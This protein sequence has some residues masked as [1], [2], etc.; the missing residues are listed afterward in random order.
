VTRRM[1]S[2]HHCTQGSNAV[3][4][5]PPPCNVIENLITCPGTGPTHVVAPALTCVQAIPGQAASTFPN[6]P[7]LSKG[8]LNISDEFLPTKECLGLE[9][10]PRLATLSNKS[11]R[12]RIGDFA[13]QSHDHDH[14]SITTQRS[15][16]EDF[17]DTIVMSTSLTV[18]AE[19]EQSSTRF[20]NSSSLGELAPASAKCLSILNSAPAFLWYFPTWAPYNSRFCRRAFGTRF[21]IRILFSAAAL[22]AL[23]FICFRISQSRVVIMP[24]FVSHLYISISSAALPDLFFKI[25]PK[26]GQSQPDAFVGEDS[27][28][29]EMV[30]VE[31][32]SV[33]KFDK[34]FGHSAVILDF[35]GVRGGDSR[36]GAGCPSV[37]HKTHLSGSRIFVAGHVCQS[38]PVRMSGSNYVKCNSNSNCPTGVRNASG[39]V[40]SL[41][42]G[43]RSA[44]SLEP[45][46]PEFAATSAVSAMCIFPSPKEALLLRCFEGETVNLE[47][48]WMYFPPAH[49]D[50]TSRVH[51]II[52]FA[53]M[54][55]LFWILRHF[56]A[57][58]SSRVSKF[59]NV[60]AT[61]FQFVLV[62]ESFEMQPFDVCRVHD[63]PSTVPFIKASG[64]FSNLE[65]RRKP[66]LVRQQNLL[67][68]CVTSIG[69]SATAVRPHTLLQDQSQFLRPSD[70]L[71]SSSH[72]FHSSQRAADFDNIDGA[73][74]RH[75][76]A[77]PLKIEAS[78]LMPVEFC[79]LGT[80]QFK[81]QEFG[82]FEQVFGLV[83][84]GGVLRC[85][86]CATC[87]QY[88][89]CGALSRSKH[90][91]FEQL[92]DYGVLATLYMHHHPN[93]R[94][95]RDRPQLN[96]SRP[97]F[98]LNSKARSLASTF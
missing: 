98:G 65:M 8:A 72:R 43:L 71:D 78:V 53:V 23:L 75:G 95:G 24:K 35:S 38:Y 89:V 74:V 16:R 84:C 87:S 64:Y 57:A 10:M 13:R 77:R 22:I 2:L 81:S 47:S 1:Q 3:C 33:E 88:F 50:N 61:L 73:D 56:I 32:V 36:G 4:V 27:S 69:T 93:H 42:H 29:V 55:R 17:S 58:C 67:S 28:S 20:T 62:C 45:Q 41:Y 63:V 6:E 91:L 52:Q 19:L 46:T 30:A 12:R 96:Y 31:S 44:L 37:L 92:T 34:T 11:H 85:A 54:F 80:D 9:M 86:V 76:Y 5:E 39:G 59:T 66:I 15:K 26:L 7:T 40:V 48:A 60:C 49:V 83:F 51:G 25:H 68:N 70:F 82:R 18:N 90:T 14:P 97:G 21:N 79:R 94:A